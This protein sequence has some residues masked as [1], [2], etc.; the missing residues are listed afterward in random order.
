MEK[1]E[2]KDHR[3]YVNNHY[4]TRDRIV[5][6]YIDLIIR[7]NDPFSDEVKRINQLILSK[8][9]NSGLIYIKEKAWKQVIKFHAVFI[10]K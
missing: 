4:C 8:W 1:I 2:R 10:G 7:D 5:P 3:K 6:Y 9:S